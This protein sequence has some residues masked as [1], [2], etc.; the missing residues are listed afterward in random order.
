MRVS[1]LLGELLGSNPDAEVVVCFKVLNDSGEYF[2]LFNETPASFAEPYPGD[3]GKFLVHATTS[4]PGISSQAMGSPVM[5]E[6]AVAFE[7]EADRMD[8]EETRPDDEDAW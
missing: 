6:L 1:D 5:R 3:D 8:E 4:L 7:H 2:L